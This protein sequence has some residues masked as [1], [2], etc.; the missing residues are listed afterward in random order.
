MMLITCVLL[1]CKLVI[2]MF[3]FLG[4]RNR[5]LGLFATFSRN[6]S[7]PCIWGKIRLIGWIVLINSAILFTVR[8]AWPASWNSSE[9]S[10]LKFSYCQVYYVWDQPSRHRQ[11]VAKLGPHNWNRSTCGYPE[12]WKL[13]WHYSSSWFNETSSREKGQREG[14]KRKREREREGESQG[15]WWYVPFNKWNF[16]DLLSKDRKTSQ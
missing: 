16:K 1:R 14:T 8:L 13:W 11:L 6:L 15:G 3:S 7:I 2:S 5:N 10:K 12:V 4:L 9:Y